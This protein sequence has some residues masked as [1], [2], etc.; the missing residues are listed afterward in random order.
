VFLSWPN[1]DLRR[2]VSSL[3]CVDGLGEVSAWCLLTSKSAK[4]TC[5]P[6]RTQFAILIREYPVMKNSLTLKTKGKE[7]AKMLPTLRKPS[8]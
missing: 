1:S 7:G 3:R 5:C 2:L 6:L 8:V 4:T